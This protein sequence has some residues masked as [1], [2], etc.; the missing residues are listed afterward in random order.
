MAKYESLQ[1]P[2]PRKEVIKDV[3]IYIQWKEVDLP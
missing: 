1:F 3:T 2:V